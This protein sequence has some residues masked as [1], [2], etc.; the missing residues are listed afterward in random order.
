MSNKTTH[1]IT[2]AYDLLAYL[3]MGIYFISNIQLSASWV[4]TAMSELGLIVIIA[5]LLMVVEFLSLCAVE[6]PKADVVK[7]CC[8]G[9][10]KI[11]FCIFISTIF[12]QNFVLANQGFFN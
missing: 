12:F 2:S 1:I 7:T 6:D 11:I 8:K 10:S 3:L 9:A 4:V 5:Y